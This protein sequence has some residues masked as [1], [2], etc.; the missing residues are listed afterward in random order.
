M[1]PP[2]FIRILQRPPKL[3]PSQKKTFTQALKSL[4]NPILS[5]LAPAVIE[6]SKWIHCQSDRLRKYGVINQRQRFYC[7]TCRQSLVC[8]RGTAYFY[9]HKP[10]LWQPY[11][12]TMLE[13]DYIRRCS[14][15]WGIC[16]TTSFDLWHGCQYQNP[17]WNLRS[18]RHR[19]LNATQNR[20]KNK[21]EGIVEAD[22]AFFRAPQKGEQT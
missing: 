7:N 20:Y 21:L 8:T 9:Q 22:K 18:R 14:K 1:N 15:E 11:L 2:Y 13:R 12:E 6:H 4:V 19:Y 16:V 3:D 17:V 5:K 10:E